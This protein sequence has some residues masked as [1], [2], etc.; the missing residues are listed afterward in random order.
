MISL[1]R[2][3]IEALSQEE[4]I[5]AKALG[6]DIEPRKRTRKSHSKCTS[7]KP[8]I[9]ITNVSCRL[10]NSMHTKIFEMAKQGNFLHSKEIGKVP[11]K[12]ELH[13]MKIKSSS[14]TVRHCCNCYNYLTNLTKENL[15]QKF[16]SY[17]KDY[18]NFLA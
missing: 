9:L 7:S 1:T 13:D 16:L 4:Q 15:V 3:D 14:Y 10:C 6:L 17:I 5:L 18:R 11:P 8:Y 2:A 12:E